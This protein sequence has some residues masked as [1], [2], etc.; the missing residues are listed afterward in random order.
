MN[1]RMPNERAGRSADRSLGEGA[2]RGLKVEREV[3]IEM[4]VE[5]VVPGACASP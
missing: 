4:E 5:E 3:A 1:G 2:N